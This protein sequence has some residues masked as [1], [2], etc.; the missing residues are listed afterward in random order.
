[1]KTPLTPLRSLLL[2]AAALLAGLSAAQACT[3]LL[4]KT[5]DDNYVYGRTMEFGFELKSK[6]VVV[7]RGISFTGTG[8]KKGQDG[9]KWTGKYGFTGMNAAN[10]PLVCDGLNE[11]GL[12]AGILYFP[13]YAEYTKPADADP[14][15]SIAPWEFLTW[16]LSSF[17]TVDE[18]K[19]AI[20]EVQVIGVKFPAFG[21]VAPFHYTLH[22]ANGKSIVIEPTGG[23]LKV[24]D[25]PY[26]VLTNSPTFD[27][28][29]TNLRN[30]TKLSDENAPP[31][32][33]NGNEIDSFGEGSGWLGLPGDPTPPSRFIRAMAFSM[34][35][36]PV[37]NGPESV[38]LVEH[39]MNN[40]DL[41]RGIIRDS[42]SDVADYTQW[43]VIADIANRV[44][45]VKTYNNQQ[46][47]AIDLNSF[48]LDAKSPIVAAIADELKAPALTF[49]K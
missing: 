8:A 37:P 33:I 27:W 31:L 22:D 9:L 43:T 13:G 14:A 20:N 49:S 41:P 17:A 40:F 32:K 29:L 25:N 46:L 34:S 28:H 5:S 6:A 11:K 47:Q 4:V 19:A 18:V 1:M 30:Y 16:C 21:F 2:G 7:P 44:Y 15:K 23:T 3:S 48:D 26:G 35:P 42:K 39:I 12:A 45:Y 10:Q 38:R 24:Y 36:V